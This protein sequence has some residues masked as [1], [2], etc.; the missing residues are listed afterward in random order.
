[1][2]QVRPDVGIY[3][4]GRA[5]PKRILT[6][7]DLEAM[8]DTSDEWITTRTG[9]KQRCIADPEIAASDLGWEAAVQALQAAE[10]APDELDL[11]IVATTTPDM[12]FPSTACLIQERLKAKRA[13]AFDLAAAC[14]GF[15]YGLEIGRS[16]VKAGYQ[17][18][19][20]IGVDLLSRLLDYT[21]RSTC[22]LFGDGA[23]AAVLGPTSAGYGILASEIGADGSGAKMLHVD[24]YVKMS[25]REV[26][27]FAVKVI[28]DSTKRVAKQAAIDI[29]DISWFVPHQANIR[30]INA[31]AERLHIDSERIFVNVDRYGN[32]SAASIPIALTELA[33]SGRLRNGD[34]VLLVGFG[35]GLTWGSTILRWGGLIT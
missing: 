18:V 32:T 34:L 12:A 3:G 29:S 6:N 20:V 21:D 13:A 31:A 10:V 14:S 22:V 24:E 9:I 35:A 25:G 26:F 8:V 7:Q 23:G 30:I 28:V 27:K 5:V 33:E 2:T 15:V 4:L 17:K 19:L 11:I 16:M 1:M